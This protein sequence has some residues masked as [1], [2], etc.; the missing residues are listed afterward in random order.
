M[1]N[2]SLVMIVC[3]SISIMFG[4]GGNGATSSIGGENS[5]VDTNKALPAEIADRLADYEMTKQELLILKQDREL[6]YDLYL[7]KGDTSKASPAD[8]A[9][10][11]EIEEKLFAKNEELSSMKNDLILKKNEAD[12]LKDKLTEANMELENTKTELEEAKNNVSV[13]PKDA[14]DRVAVEGGILMGA[15]LATKSNERG[16][17]II[18]MIND[19][20]GKNPSEKDKFTEIL[21]SL[22]KLPKV[23]GTYN[24]DAATNF[25]EIAALTGKIMTKCPSADDLPGIVHAIIADEVKFAKSADI[26]LLIDT[27]ST[28]NDEIDKLK[29][30]IS[31]M[32]PELT[33]LCKDIRIS[34]VTYRDIDTKYGKVGYVTQIEGSFTRD[35][36][37]IV[38]AVRKVSVND[39][40]GNYDIPEAVYEGL[41]STFNDL[42]WSDRADKRIVILIGDAPAGTGQKFMIHPKRGKTDLKAEHKFTLEDIKKQLESMKTAMMTE[43]MPI[44]IFPIVCSE[45]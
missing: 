25:T 34:I 7:T 41:M 32:Y 9:K 28:M 38:L 24:A 26:S 10:I 13:V 43:E 8:L 11:K 33:K 19:F 1:R 16:L 40:G 30:S 3:L 15:A 35:L 14:I 27:T 37:E 21:E 18:A 42:A 5:F 2:V 22:S 20:V 36:R 4:C 29:R 45:K 31:G 17:E 44:S 23:N 39:K 6:L 12:S